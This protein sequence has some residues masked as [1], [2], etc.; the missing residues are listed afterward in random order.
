MKQKSSKLGSK[1]TLYIVVG[2]LLL[3][4]LFTTVLVYNT[5]KTVKDSLGEMAYILRKIS[6]R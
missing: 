2:I 6:Q 1:I 3:V 5:N 4:A